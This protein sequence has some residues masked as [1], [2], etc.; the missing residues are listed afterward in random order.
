MIS[1]KAET[2][3]WMPNFLQLQTRNS[4]K[5]SRLLWSPSCV[6]KFVVRLGKV[7]IT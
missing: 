3:F 1:P 2:P 6:D 5:E 4:V 7:D